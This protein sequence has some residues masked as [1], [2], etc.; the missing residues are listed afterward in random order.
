M[1]KS[2]LLIMPLMAMLLLVGC[3]N[4][5]SS[6]S[7]TSS[8]PESSV[9][10]S[11][12][13]SS[14]AS[15]SPVVSSEVSSSSSS[16]SASSEASSSEDSSS[17]SS[18]SQTSSDS[19]SSEEVKVKHTFNVI[20]Y[21]SLGATFIFDKEDGYSTG[22]TVS[23]TIKGSYI[24]YQKDSFNNGALIDIAGHKIAFNTEVSGSDLVGSFVMPEV[25][26]KEEVDFIVGTY[27]AY[28]SDLTAADKKITIEL[29]DGL[30]AF[31][32]DTIKEGATFSSFAIY[33][34]KTVALTK[35]SYKIGNGEFVE[36]STQYVS[37]YQD[38]ASISLSGLSVTDDITIKIEA[39]EVSAYNV[40]IVGKEYVT[41]SSEPSSSYI[42]GETVSFYYTAISG[43]SVTCKV[44][45]DDG[46]DILNQSYYGSNWKFTMPGKDVTITFTAT[47]Y[48]TVTVETD[49]NITS[50]KVYTRSGYYSSYSES[51]DN[52]VEPGSTFY[53]SA[54]VKDGYKL[55]TAS[56]KGDDTQTYTASS[57]YALNNKIGY[58]ITAPSDGSSFT[59]VISTI[60]CGK[61]TI[62]EDSTHFTS[63]AVKDSENS[64]TES[65]FNSYGAGDSFVLVPSVVDGFVLTGATISDGTTSTTVDAQIN[66]SGTS[67]VKC[68]MPENGIANV[69]FTFA[70][71]YSVTLD[72]DLQ[73]TTKVRANFDSG[74][75]NYA[76]GATVKLTLQVQFGYELSKIELAYD[77]TTTELKI[78]TNSYGY[79][80]VE[81]K[82]PA[83]NVTLKSTIVEAEK[84][85]VSF[86]YAN[87]STKTVSSISISDTNNSFA[88]EA[89]DVATTIGPVT[90]TSEI[91]IGN[92]INFSVYDS[93]YYDNTTYTY[94]ENFAVTLTITYTDD[95]TEI[96]QATYEY[97]TYEV[98]RIEITKTIKSFSLVITDKAAE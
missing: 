93:N 85:S 69:T 13:S 96:K 40:K 42:E 37:W 51:S 50:F 18:S 83:Y 30:V 68:T 89:N 64:Y 10:S 75:S 16:S 20:C 80:Y 8:E 72:A 86:S 84:V 66:Y 87:N 27:S 12:S 97:G 25:G 70:T 65:T 71:S 59:V 23:Y 67:Y 29:T 31:T 95:T 33:R 43:Y 54:E 24:S 17:S 76:E 15:S 32:P 88:I 52:K 49:D 61:I 3:D 77:D 22:D 34:A 19:S 38:F 79:K 11:S 94:L 44:T 26:E 1:R 46:E 63:V 2:K 92:Y 91:V 58:Q 53:I 21:S 90:N 47:E 74:T 9:S 4:N 7:S 39:K 6:S 56:I 55:G 36:V 48:P 35:V 28:V 57:Q 82:M 78:K 98:S 5:T 60:Q 45:T 41:F 62:T 81:F 14:T 73:D